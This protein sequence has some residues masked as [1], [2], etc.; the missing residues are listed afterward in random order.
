[1]PDI[2]E[3]VRQLELVLGQVCEVVERLEA[4]MTV[5]MKAVAAQG[6]PAPEQPKEPSEGEIIGEMEAVGCTWEEAR[7]ALMSKE[8]P[9]EQER[10]GTDQKDV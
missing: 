1:M 8:A 6:A 4:S 10:E 5:I 3:R 2:E 7:I 9:N